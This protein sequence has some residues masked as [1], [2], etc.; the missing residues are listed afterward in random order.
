MTTLGT[1]FLALV[2]SL[3]RSRLLGKLTCRGGMLHFFNKDGND[4]DGCTQCTTT[5]HNE[6]V[7]NLQWV[8]MAY[9]K[10]TGG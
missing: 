1:E 8:W 2:D 6:A 7:F 9:V 3:R 4:T 5:T 10:R